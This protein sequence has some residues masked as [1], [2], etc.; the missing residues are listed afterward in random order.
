MAGFSF[1]KR[2]TQLVGFPNFPNY[3]DRP[4]KGGF[5]AEMGKNQTP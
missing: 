4:V 3:P 5:Y 1:Y 2:L